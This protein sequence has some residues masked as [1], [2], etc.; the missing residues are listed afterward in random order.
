M[1]KPPGAHGRKPENR[2]SNP[3]GPANKNNKVYLD[4]KV[5]TEK[6]VFM[7]SGGKDSALALHEIL[8][9]GNCEVVALMT[10]LTKDYDRVSVHGFQRVLLEQQAV[11]LG[12]PLE[13]VLISKD[14]RLENYEFEVRKGLIEFFKRGV[15]S[16]VFGDVSLED[17]R[18]YREKFLS[19]LNM[20]GIFPLWNRNTL[21]VAHEFISEGFKAVITCVDSKC[22]GKEFVGRIFDC[23]FIAE[24]PANVDPC[25]ENGEFHS[26]V[27]DGPLF[28]RRILFN[29]GKTVLRE[30]RFYYC[31]LMLSPPAKQESEVQ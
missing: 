23:E 28:N 4:G 8:K 5:M 13:K 9:T 20:K 16:V 6:V 11:S 10:T 24:L 3:L 31:D 25:G 14:A 17:V 15:S 7:W 19:K 2:G 29:L 27:Y 22:L 30:N 18:E 26:F 21:K 1:R 12:F